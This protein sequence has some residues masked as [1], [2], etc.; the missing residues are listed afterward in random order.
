MPSQVC[1]VD[2]LRS[3]AFG[4]TSGSYVELG[5][6]FQHPMR[7]VKIVNNTNGDMIISFDGVTDN[8]FIPAGGFTLYDVTTNR[9][10]SATYF[11]F[12]N[13]TQVFVKRSSVPT[14]GSIYMV[15]L[16]GQGE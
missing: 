13:G 4:A 6:E 7:L 2:E 9:E 5:G 8:D 14:S 1:H 3:V 15:C 16:Y 11:V 12:A 10:E